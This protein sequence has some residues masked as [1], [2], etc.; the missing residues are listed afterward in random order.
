MSARAPAGPARTGRAAFAL[1][2]AALLLAGC[3]VSGPPEPPGP[4]PERPSG[5]NVSVT[6]EARVG[7]AGIR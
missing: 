5:P 2:A 6:G 1:L 3:G 4:P 7:L